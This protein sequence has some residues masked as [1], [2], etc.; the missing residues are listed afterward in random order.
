[1]GD[2]L[3]AM[4]IS[5]AILLAVIAFIVVLTIVVVK[6]GEAAMHDEA[7]QSGGGHTH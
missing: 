2:A 4:A 7:K 1:M 5:G 3:S 6:R